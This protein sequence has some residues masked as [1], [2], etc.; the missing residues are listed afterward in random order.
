VV[1]L[2]PEKLA[3]V[4]VVRPIEMYVFEICGHSLSLPESVAMAPRKVS[5]PR[6]DQDCDAFTQVVS[7]N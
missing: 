1:K 6:D 7:C 2:L 5:G 4:K 3:V